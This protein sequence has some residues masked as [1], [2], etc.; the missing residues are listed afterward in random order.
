MRLPHWVA[1]RTGLWHPAFPHLDIPEA[2][3]T[4]LFELFDWITA[5]ELIE[6][7]NAWFERGIWTNKSVPERGWPAITH[8]QWRC[9]AAKAAAHALPRGLGDAADALGLEVRKDDEGSAVMKKMA[10]PRKPTV[11]D[12]DA[13]GVLH[14]PCMA[15]EGTGRTISF[16]KD[17][18]PT[19]KGQRC[20]DC[21]GNGWDRTKQGLP[22]MPIL[23][24]ESA[25]LFER[26]FAYCRADIL[27]EEGI[28]HALPD[29]S[30]E[31]TEMYLLDQAINE[32]GF[33]LDTE[34]I[35]V[36]LELIDEE[37][38]DLNA[39]L[40]TL[41]GGAV[42]KA[43]QR[44]KMT[45][46]F[47][48]NGL[49]L[50]DTQADTLDDALQREDLRPD[51]RRGLELVRTLGRSSTAK[52]EAMRN[53]VC[54]DERVHGG[55]LYHGAS[56][57]RWTGAGI[58]PHNFPRGE[59]K[60]DIEYIWDVLK[61][62]ERGTAEVAFGGVMS[63][64]SSALRGCIVPAPGKQMYVADFN[65]IECR[66]LF[67]VAG[68]QTGLDIFRNKIDP[69]NDMAST[70]YGRKIDR[71][72][73]DAYEGQVGKV[74]ILGLGYQMGAS[75]F[76]ETAKVM[77][78]VDI[79]EDV[80]CVNCEDWMKNHRGFRDGCD[81]PTPE[82]DVMTSVIV[83]NAYR[84][85]F[86]KVAQLWKD[87]EA[88]A[89]NAV[90][91]KGQRVRAGKVTWF[92]EGRFLYCELPSGRKLAY[93]D[94]VI[95][96]K[97]TPW[98]KKVPQLTYMGIDPYTRQWKRQSAYGGLLVENIVQAI[99]RD[100]MAMAMLRCEESGVY[101]PI[102]SVHDEMIAEAAIGDGDVHEF[103]Q[104]MAALPEW[105]PGCPVT[106]EGWRGLRYRK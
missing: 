97:E 74:A 32:R 30:A 52:Y 35:D 38:I 70:I 15:C 102:L 54:P 57:G 66:V 39:E 9:S 95:R 23:Y 62:R 93:P 63:A 104:L 31:E 1:G 89:I 24:H 28:S 25:E 76:V 3:D 36:A 12:W 96:S 71:K 88:A 91:L 56:T 40:A 72:G 79:V 90:R 2:D 105:A 58:Q 6:A 106:A 13:H 22:P 87:Q 19:K 80:R 61:L 69:Y 45:A 16:K 64:L 43:T 10:K 44:A 65:A 48:E 42:V 98:G 101:V 82:S 26:L 99:A 59:V 14:R 53:W 103:E 92:T 8:R 86:W 33:Q 83:V 67:W 5:G 41:T 20:A 21:Q 100:L 17:G 78:G 34:A 27:A 29:L 7:H 85:K 77:A 73:A 68:D 81:E 37:F 50:E 60:E 18:T 47:A 11:A 4:D 46:W 51:V 49:D 75:K 55:L 94:P 84:S